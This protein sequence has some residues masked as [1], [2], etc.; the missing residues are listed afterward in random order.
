MAFKNLEVTGEVVQGREVKLG[1]PLAK[2][3]SDG[4]IESMT[5]E[6]YWSKPGK[7][8]CRLSGVIFSPDGHYEYV[9]KIENIMDINKIKVFIFNPANEQTK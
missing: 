4:Y 9:S 8:N 1:T 5:L 6:R 2:T 3:I 7:Y